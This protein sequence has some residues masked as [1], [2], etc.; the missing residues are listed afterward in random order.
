[1]AFRIKPMLSSDFGVV[2]FTKSPQHYLVQWLFSSLGEP[3]QETGALNVWHCK[4]TGSD[5]VWMMIHES[6]CKCL[7]TSRVCPFSKINKVFTFTVLSLLADWINLKYSSMTK[8]VSYLSCTL[9][10]LPTKLCKSFIN[11]S[12]LPGK[13]ARPFWLLELECLSNKQGYCLREIFKS[14]EP[15]PQFQEPIINYWWIN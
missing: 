15:K 11:I 12:L 4:V 8:F 3:L 2:G 13:T 9:T 5:P 6:C 7:V 14:G 1:M 10:S